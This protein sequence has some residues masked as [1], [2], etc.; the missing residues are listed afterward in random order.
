MSVIT[1]LLISLVVY[2]LLGIVAIVMAKRS[3]SEESMRIAKVYA[4]FG[5]AILVMN[6]IGIIIRAIR[7]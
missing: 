7:A 4:W 6:V 3:S 2:M 1:V 5:L